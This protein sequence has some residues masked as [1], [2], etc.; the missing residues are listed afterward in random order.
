MKNSSVER[1]SN[2]LVLKEVGGYGQKLLKE[3]R[4]LIVGIGGLGC[5][6]L[7]YT[8]GSGIGTIGLIAVSYT[9]LT[10]PTKRIV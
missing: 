4:V 9:H 7:Q 8:A 3:S 5:P 6:V 1:Y 2:H 10:L